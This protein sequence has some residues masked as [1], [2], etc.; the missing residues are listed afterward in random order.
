[1]TTRMRVALAAVAGAAMIAVGGGGGACSPNS[2]KTGAQAAAGMGGAKPAAGQ[3]AATFTLH[4]L[5]L[6]NGFK[7]YDSSFFGVP[8]YA[9]S[10]GVLY[11]RGV[12][13][14]PSTIP[15][16]EFARLPA[17]ARPLHNLYIICYN[18]GGAGSNLTDHISVGPDG[19]MG[20]ISGA[21][22]P[23]NPSLAAI[24][25]PLSSRGQI[26]SRFGTLGR[27]RGL[28]AARPRRD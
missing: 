26:V 1:M 15:N 14:G 18:F 4:P 11:L 24:S 8:A 7:S 3:V 22:A 28:A 23:V 2:A 25:F 9:V 12:V 5:A 20:V 17:G 16:P 6:L 27:T 13:A 19:A 10:D 21:G